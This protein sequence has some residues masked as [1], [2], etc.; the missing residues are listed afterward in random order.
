MAK[1]KGIGKLNDIQ[2]LKRFLF[3]YK[4]VRKPVAISLEI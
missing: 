1:V 2:G 4:I 3:S